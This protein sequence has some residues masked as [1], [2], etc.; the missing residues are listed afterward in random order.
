MCA[1]RAYTQ[2]ALDCER[3]VTIR[4]PQYEITRCRLNATEFIRSVCPPS[5]NLDDYLAEFNYRANRR[6]ME[7]NLFDRLVVSGN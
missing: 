4:S 5:V 7:A 6:W 2:R 3:T 1:P